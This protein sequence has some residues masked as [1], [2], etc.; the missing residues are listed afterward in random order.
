[1]ESPTRKEILHNFQTGVI[2]AEE[3]FCMIVSLDGY[4]STR[5]HF[6]KNID[7]LR[8]TNPKKY[9]ELFTVFANYFEKP[10]SGAFLDPIGCSV[11]NGYLTSDFGYELEVELASALSLQDQSE[12]L[13]S[14]ASYV[15][16]VQEPISKQRNTSSNSERNQ[17]KNVDNTFSKNVEDDNG[18]ITSSVKTKKRKNKG[19]TNRPVVYWFRRDLR[20]YDNPALVEAASMNVPVILVF[21]WSESEEDPE[22][23]VAA[24][25]ATKLWL[26]HALNHLDKSISDRYNNRIIYRKTQSCQREILSLI[27]E[28]GAKALLIYDVYEPFLKQRDDKIC[29][30]LQRKGIECK[31]FHSYLLHEP[32]SVSAESVGM[33]GVGS[34]THFM[35]CCRQS[36]AQ[37]IGHPL[38]YPPT[39]PKPD[40]FPSSSSLHDLELA[41]MPRRKD[42][43]IVCY[44]FKIKKKIVQFF[45]VLFGKASVL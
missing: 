41:K 4:D 39:L 12:S 33:R 42:G 19:S 14:K 22:G 31:R 28:T 18:S 40:Q 13:N 8:L 2:D 1:M 15:S 37:P 23:V 7:F 32:G 45:M 27:E 29:A 38:D 9:N 11:E 25:G 20:L 24:G 16:V 17:P 6:L 35:E 26:H 3:C 30:E 21:L 36:D 43:S 34:V 44:H 10:P 5:Q